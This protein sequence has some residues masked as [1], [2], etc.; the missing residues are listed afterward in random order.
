METPNAAGSLMHE[1]ISTDIQSGTD[2]A[3]GRTVVSDYF[4]Q[5]FGP[6]GIREIEFE[7]VPFTSEAHRAFH[8]KR[9]RSS[10]SQ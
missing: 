9:I 3:V 5:L 6:L 7:E 1:A 8:A 10:K 2:R 4:E